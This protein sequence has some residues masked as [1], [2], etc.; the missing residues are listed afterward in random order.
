M[1]DAPALALLLD[2]PTSTLQQ[3]AEDF[4]VGSLRHGVSP[5]LLSPWAGPL[6]AELSALFRGLLEQGCPT[7][8]LAALCEGMHAAKSKMESAENNLY[9]A[10]SGPE[11]P[12]IP[13]VDTGT[14]VRS[15]FVEAQRE[16][17]VTSYVFSNA[18][19]LLEPLADRMAGDP[20]FR[21]RFVVDLTHQRKAP[22]EPLPVVANRFKQHFLKN[23]WAGSA[24]PEFWHDDRNFHESE[25]AKR[26][27]MHAKVVVIDS[28]AALV[29]SANFTAAAHHR[30]IEAGI[31]IRHLTQVR[32]IRNYFDS[33][34][35]TKQLVPLR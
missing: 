31:L 34:I 23:H 2:L 10:L 35:A 16:V 12:G 14:V 7:S 1:K 9:L 24:I 33:L 15:L 5:G 22:D 3:L 26:G 29:T 21:V 11:V 8:V 20:A 30:N 27:I 13:V 18:F 6:A 19:E 4:R 17:L 28:A 25:P 32:T